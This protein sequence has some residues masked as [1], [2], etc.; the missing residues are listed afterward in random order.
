M[1]KHIYIYTHTLYGKQILDNYF[2]P[3]PHLPN[4]QERGTLKY[5]VL[6]SLT[7]LQILDDPRSIRCVSP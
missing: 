4:L 3:I 6:S 2:H 5:G 7:L 1:E